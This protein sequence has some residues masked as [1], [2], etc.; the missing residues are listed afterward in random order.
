M[1]AENEKV[2]FKQ[3]PGRSRPIDVGADRP[4]EKGGRSLV[5]QHDPQPDWGR[6]MENRMKV[7]RSRNGP[8][9]IF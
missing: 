3:W 2:P 7:K 9:G 6:D 4:E 1:P 8:Q 5:T